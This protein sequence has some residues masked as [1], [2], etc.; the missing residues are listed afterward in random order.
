MLHKL[1]SRSSICIDEETELTIYIGFSLL[2]GWYV[3]RLNCDSAFGC[4]K[5]ILV[6]SLGSTYLRKKEIDVLSLAEY[7]LEIAERE[8]ERERHVRMS[9]HLINRSLCC[10]E[11]IDSRL[12]CNML[13]VLSDWTNQVKEERDEGATTAF[14]EQ[15]LERM[16]WIKSPVLIIWHNLETATETSDPD[17]IWNK[18]SETE[19]VRAY[20]FHTAS[21]VVTVKNW[22]VEFLIMN[23]ELHSNSN[24]HLIIIAGNNNCKG[25]I[26]C[27]N[28]MYTGNQV[29]P[30][31]NPFLDII[32][33]LK[34]QICRKE[35]TT[36]KKHNSFKNIF[37]IKI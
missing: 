8:R 4:C 7:N 13:V 34:M 10:L 20:R 14:L 35:V 29:I 32:I 23:I 31:Q 18:K 37:K 16:S 15:N 6:G 25:K 36:N 26:F 24:L 17:L 3:R 11:R 33:P 30:A 1:P 9:H 21:N 28:A 2:W 19:V 5:K 12:C 27:Q 22:L